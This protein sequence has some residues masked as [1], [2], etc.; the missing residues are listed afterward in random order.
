[1]LTLSEVANLL[2]LLTKKVKSHETRLLHVEAASGV[3]AP[4]IIR[5]MTAR[6]Q[7][8]KPGRKAIYTEKMNF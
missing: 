6:T 7:R 5:E 3:M 1:M 2:R 8:K 4:E